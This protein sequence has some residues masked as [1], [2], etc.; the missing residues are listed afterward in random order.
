MSLEERVSTVKKGLDALEAR[1]KE[2]ADY[3]E[4][5]EALKLETEVRLS[6]A[7]ADSQGLKKKVED[8]ERWVEEYRQQGVGLQEKCD[9][10]SKDKEGLERKLSEA[11]ASQQGFKEFLRPI[12]K[13]LIE[14]E[15]LI[16]E[17]MQSKEQ[18]QTQPY[19]MTKTVGDFT[20]QVVRQ[21][22]T[23]DPNTT[24]GRLLYLI[25]DGFFN[26]PTTVPKI[27]KELRDQF[28]EVK[29]DEVEPELAFFVREEVIHHTV[30]ASGGH[31]YQLRADAKDRVKKVVRGDQ[32]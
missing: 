20:V 32:G 19:G 23:L 28:I 2:Q 5:Y 24:R 3:K 29:R 15:K 17:L 9:Q 22:L 6:N 7:E 21:P 11:N 4:Q 26:K 14:G 25:T 13:E 12:V 8:L 27:V 16:P 31:V 1:L 30:L 10:L 18:A